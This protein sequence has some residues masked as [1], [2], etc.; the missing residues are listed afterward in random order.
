LMVAL[1]VGGL[2]SLAGLTVVNYHSK[3]TL[4]Q[5]VCHPLQSADSSGAVTLT[6]PNGS[7]SVRP[8]LADRGPQ[9]E[10]IFAKL[11][12]RADPPDSPPPR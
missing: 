11:I 7:S 2:P 9:L 3:P 4:T 10:P 12:E 6:V 5:N 8:I 1:M